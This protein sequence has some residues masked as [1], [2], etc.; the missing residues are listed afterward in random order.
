MKNKLPTI[1]G[2]NVLESA[3]EKIRL[4][5]S[6]L[7]PIHSDLC[8]LSLCSKVFNSAIKFLDIDITAITNTDVNYKN[9]CS[10]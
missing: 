1:Q 6:Q 9:E 4:F 5:D 10:N 8:Q 2:L 3:I 7:T